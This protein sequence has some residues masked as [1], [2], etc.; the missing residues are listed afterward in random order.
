MS[1]RRRIG[2]WLTDV[3]P[4]LPLLTGRH[5]HFHLQT[6]PWALTWTPSLTLRFSNISTPSLPAPQGPHTSSSPA[7][8]WPHTSPSPDEQFTHSALEARSIDVMDA[9]ETKASHAVAAVDGATFTSSDSI[10][11]AYDDSESDSSHVQQSPISAAISDAN[12]SE[13]AAQQ[14]REPIIRHVE[15]ADLS[16]ADPV[17]Q[18]DH[19]LRRQLQAQHAAN[20]Q[21][22]LAAQHSDTADAGKRPND[23]VS[24]YSS[25]QPGDHVTTLQIATSD[26]PIG[27]ATLPIANQDQTAQRPLSVP[28]SKPKPH[29][30]VPLFDGG[31]FDANYNSKYQPVHFA[32][33]EGLQRAVLEAVITGTLH[34]SSAMLLHL[35]TVKLVLQEP[36][37]IMIWTSM[38]PTSSIKCHFFMKI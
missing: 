35:A 26:E 33:P 24:D 32:T 20:T 18:Q 22:M 15:A 23:I 11:P 37:C 9:L 36:V 1:Y 29:K 38:H 28:A 8:L 21:T 27:E 34:L 30:I 25:V 16:S 3:T 4:L 13:S 6:A 5:C 31:D 2:R 12:M 14:K 10:Q 7:A 19:A 17:Q